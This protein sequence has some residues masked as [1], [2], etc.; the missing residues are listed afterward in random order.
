MVAHT[1][2][3]RTRLPV[4]PFGRQLRSL[5]SWELTTVMFYPMSRVLLSIESKIS[6]T[7]RNDKR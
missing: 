1:P 7:I 3:K 4:P 5:P 6:A 2:L